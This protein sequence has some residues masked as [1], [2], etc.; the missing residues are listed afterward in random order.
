MKALYRHG[1]VTIQ[2]LERAVDAGFPPMVDL[3]AWRDEELPW[4]DVWDA[5]H[6]VVMVGYDRQR[7]FFMDPGTLTPGAYAYLD[8]DELDDRWHDLAGS[9][10]RRV[11]RMVIFARGTT[12]PVVLGGPLLEVATS[13]G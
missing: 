8:R 4:K 1:D 9:E 13:L 2:D 7:L 6:Y 11:E 10:E 3:Q 5:G 12:Q